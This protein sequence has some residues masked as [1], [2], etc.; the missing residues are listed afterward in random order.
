MLRRNFMLGLVPFAASLTTI[1]GCGGEKAD[2][3]KPVEV[4]D[5]MKRQAEA[6]DAYLTEQSQPKKKAPA[7]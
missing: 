2:M 3:S 6:S 5:E 7:K 1:V 4:T